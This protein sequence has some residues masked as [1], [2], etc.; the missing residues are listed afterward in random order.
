MWVL[1]IHHFA[2]TEVQLQQNHFFTTEQLFVQPRN[3]KIDC[4]YTFD[5]YYQIDIITHFQ[6]NV[7]S[8]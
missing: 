4:L 7:L 2:F 3:T 8:F 1:V 6:E 5:S